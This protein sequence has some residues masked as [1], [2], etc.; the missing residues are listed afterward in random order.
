MQLAGILAVIA[1]SSLVGCTHAA[2]LQDQFGMSDYRLSF[3]ERLRI[4]KAAPN[5]V[6][7]KVLAVNEVGKPRRSPGDFRIKT[8]LTRIK[9]DVEE[10]IKG[11][12][13]SNRMNFYFFTYSSQNK[14]DLGVPRYEPE[15]GQRRVYF[16][17]PWQ[18][19]YRSVGDVTN[20]N[21]P[22]R[23][24]THARGFCQG[25]EPGCCIA[26]ILLVPTQDIDVQWFVHE[27]GPLSA[28]AAGV[29]CS[30]RKAQELLQQLAQNP[31]TRIADSATDIMSMLGQWWPQLKSASR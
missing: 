27:L 11:D 9:I 24:G 8:Q 10:V 19:S 22:V 28:Y 14:V 26:E 15:V 13:R 2:D 7:G 1:L 29:L 31:D 21:L 18:D 30:P 4:E 6:L 5:I 25:K 17:R 3:D 16:L 23:S 12:V 20:Y